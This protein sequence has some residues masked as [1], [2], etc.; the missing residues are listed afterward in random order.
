MCLGHYLVQQQRCTRQ[1]AGNGSHDALLFICCPQAFFKEAY[2]TRMR[3]KNE[4]EERGRGISG[5]PAGR[6]G[7][8]TEAW[9]ENLCQVC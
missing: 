4:P 2:K 8:R 9:L 1:H 6:N 7:G 3:G 5:G